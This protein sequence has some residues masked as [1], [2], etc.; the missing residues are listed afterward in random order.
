MGLAE[1]ETFLSCWGGSV[2][3]KERAS[4]ALVFTSV[5]FLTMSTTWA[6]T[7]CLC[8]HDVLAMMNCTPEL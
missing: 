5:C 8:H 2:Y 3:E 7:L 1:Q 6:V 4:W